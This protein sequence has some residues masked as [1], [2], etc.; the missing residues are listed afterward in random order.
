MTV[1]PSTA[2]ELV[3]EFQPLTPLG[4]PEA[5][6]VVIDL[7]MPNYEVSI[8]Q[9]V[10]PPG[11]QGNLGWQLQYSNAI[12]VPQNGGWII[13]DNEKNS[14]DIENLPTGGDWQFVGYNT[15]SYDH[16]VYLRFLLNPLGTT[17]GAG[18]DLDP[19]LLGVQPV[20]PPPQNDIF[21]DFG[22]GAIP[23]QVRPPGG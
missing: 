21:R 19:V 1:T 10:V 8:I 6:P 7:T 12:V 5:T 22:P 14:W 23:I 15:G 3:Y 13:T 18:Q 9:W 17:S 11:P 16:T 20:I 2:S 4:T